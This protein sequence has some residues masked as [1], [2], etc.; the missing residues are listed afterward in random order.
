M[1]LPAYKLQRAQAKTGIL[2]H[3]HVLNREVLPLILEELCKLYAGTNK[4][5]HNIWVS[6]ER[7]PTVVIVILY[8]CMYI[9]WNSV[10]LLPRNNGTYQRDY[11]T[12]VLLFFL[13]NLC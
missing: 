7:G 4:T 3:A 9:H 12:E 5:N 2:I 1:S 13:S 10:L 11:I 8:I 6:V